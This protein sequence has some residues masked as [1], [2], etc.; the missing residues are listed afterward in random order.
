[1]GAVGPNDSDPAEVH[2]RGL[3]V[4]GAHEEGFERQETCREE[5]DR[6]ERAAPG[7]GRDVA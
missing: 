5:Q 6:K 3:A 2:A 7:V 4:V 1:M